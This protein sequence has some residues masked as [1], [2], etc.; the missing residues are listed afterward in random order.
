MKCKK[1]GYNNV[2]QAKY[3]FRCGNKYTKKEIEEAQVK[4]LIMKYIQVKDWYDTLTLSKITGSILFKIA[5]IVFVAFIGFSMYTSYGNSFRI[6]ESKSYDFS[7]HKKNHEYYIYVHND[8]TS[9]NLYL[10]HLVD[11]YTIQT[12]EK[13][14]TKI[15]KKTIEK[16]EDYTLVASDEHYYT[17]SID[18]KNI[19]KF[20]VLRKDGE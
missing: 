20:Y 6:L 12:F 5:S 4:G 1:C 11:Q 17:I 19:I 13:S 14:G 2:R 18:S 8:S 7:Y 10:P 3:C 15:D 16:L 9:L